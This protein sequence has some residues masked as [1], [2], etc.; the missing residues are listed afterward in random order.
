MWRVAIE[1]KDAGAFHKRERKRNWKKIFKAL[2]VNPGFVPG[3]EDIIHLPGA[4]VSQTLVGHVSDF[5]RVAEPIRRRA[6]MI[7][8]IQPP[9]T[10]RDDKAA[11]VI[12]AVVYG[13]PMARESV[14][15]RSR[16]YRARLFSSFF[17]SPLLSSSLA[18][19]FYFSPL[20]PCHDFSA[21]LE[22]IFAAA[23]IAPEA[24]SP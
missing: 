13:G 8:P 20:P 19:R 5:P 23:E 24:T 16:I 21:E 18:S 11:T 14:Q 1:Q 17:F 2:F 22:N 3:I 9:L 6:A 15:A 4:R 10:E 7:F 12:I